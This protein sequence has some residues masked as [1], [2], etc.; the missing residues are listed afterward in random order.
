M[1]SYLVASFLK[2]YQIFAIHCSRL[3]NWMCFSIDILFHHELSYM[4]SQAF[5]FLFLSKNI[6][7]KNK[8]KDKTW[9]FCICSLIS[10]NPRPTKCFL[11]TRTTKEGVV[12]TPQIKMNP[13]IMFIL[14]PMVSLEYP[15]NIDTK[16][17]TNIPRV[18]LLWRHNDMRPHKNLRNSVPVQK[19]RTIGFWLFFTKN[20]FWSGSF[21]T[22]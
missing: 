15:P 12:T 13:R 7:T 8:T 22:I 17:S 3:L 5:I 2:W 20:P 16:F 21:A 6:N 4:E 19:Y 9:F 1:V 10:D 14:V 11:V 18:W